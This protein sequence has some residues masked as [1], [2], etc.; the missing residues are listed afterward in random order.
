[1]PRGPRPDPQT[2]SSERWSEYL[3]LQALW[4]PVALAN[5]YLKYVVLQSTAYRFDGHS[6]RVPALDY[7]AFFRA[8]LLIN[9]LIAP[10][11]S[12]LFLA[13]SRRA[14]A[15]RAFAV[16]CGTLLAVLYLEET[17]FRTVG[18]FLTASMIR[19][20]A[21]WIHVNPTDLPGY[22]DWPGVARIT[23]A[24]GAIVICATRAFRRVLTSLCRLPDVK[25]FVFALHAFTVIVFLAA[26]LHRLPQGSYQESIWNQIGSSWA[27]KTRHV[28]TLPGSVHEMEQQ[29][30]VSAH[31]GLTR[32][33]DPLFGRAGG[34][35]VI[36]IILETMPAR[37]MPSFESLPHFN[38]LWSHAYLSS[39]HF[40]TYPNTTRA[41]FSIYTSMYPAAAQ[42]TWVNFLGQSAPR[43]PGLI[44]SLNAAGYETAAYVGG[45]GFLF[46]D[47]LHTYQG[48]GFAK[49]VTSRLVTGR[50]DTD[51]DVLKTLEGDMRDSLSAG[52]SFAVAFLPQ[53]SHGPWPAEATEGGADGLRVQARAFME[54]VDG[55]VGEL[56]DVL[57]RGAAL[58]RTLIV[59]TADHGF[60]NSKEDPEFKGGYLNDVSFRVPF[61]LYAPAIVQEPTGVKYVTSH[62]DIS[63]SVLDLLGIDG[64]REFEQ[65]TP[66]WSEELATRRTFMWGRGHVGADGYHES[67]RFFGF[68]PY[69]NVVCEGSTLR[70]ESEGQSETSVFQ[71]IKSN[72]D[73]MSGL[74]EQWLW[75]AT[76]RGR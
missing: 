41:V 36:L 20:T 7:L 58:D 11:V 39:Q 12:A 18:R 75:A 26:L 31:I 62:I 49:V 24:L 15:P 22:V 76:H 55:W 70:C 47:D 5:L 37:Y 17:A 67:G 71:A 4:L 61:M 29:Y 51:R 65:G 10:F 35:N 42:D 56:I 28:L 73:N 57:R 53:L 3:H 13:V 66:V 43:L 27:D 30:R 52:K 40:S 44:E 54:I 21:R 68:N 6:A 46:L 14:Y 16:F 69:R 63:P 48:C 25:L 50:L 64:Q 32:K 1:M 72:I 34:Y 33:V 2:D 9:L 74:Q 19:D 38:A 60:R 8:D 59:V 45:G 23:T